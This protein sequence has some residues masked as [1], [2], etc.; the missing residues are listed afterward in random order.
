MP[1]L[2]L[3][4]QRAKEM[5]L[6]SVLLLPI[7]IVLWALIKIGFLT[8][9]FILFPVILYKFIEKNDQKLFGPKS[10]LVSP[11]LA[12]KK[13]IYLS[14]LRIK[15]DFSRGQIVFNNNYRSG[16]LINF[17]DRIKRVNKS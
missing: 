3:K 15:K 14:S 7:L 16:N 5:K 1:Y 2:R 6:K 12:L 17:L 11:V 8:Q 4:A 9:K 13:I 10:P